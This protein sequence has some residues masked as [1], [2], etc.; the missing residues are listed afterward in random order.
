[1]RESCGTVLDSFLLPY[2]DFLRLP[3]GKD[4]L[5]ETSTVVN[6]F[7]PLVVCGTGGVARGTYTT[8]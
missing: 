3:F 1:M 6:V 4:H 8:H 5:R 2:T 7:W